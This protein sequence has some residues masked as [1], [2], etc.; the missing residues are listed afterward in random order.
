MRW[1]TNR[2]FYEDPLYDI[3]YVYGAL[4]ALKYYEL[5]NQAPVSFAKNY[6]SLLGNSF[7]ATPEV[8]LK[9]FLNIDVH[10]PGLISSAVQILEYKV[11]LL[12]E[13]YSIG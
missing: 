3:N 6:I 12:T 5:L 9:E 13:E 11:R 8:L 7:D 1:I 2:L 10:D 4:L